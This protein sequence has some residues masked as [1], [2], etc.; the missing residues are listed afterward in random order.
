[1]QYYYVVEMHQRILILKRSPKTAIVRKSYL[2]ITK[3]G[4]EFV[5]KRYSCSVELDSGEIKL[6]EFLIRLLSLGGAL[7]LAL[8][9]KW[10][11]SKILEKARKNHYVTVTVLIRKLPKKEVQEV[12]EEIWGKIPKYIYV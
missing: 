10:R 6:Y 7:P 5:R 3:E 9:R 12:V 1:M 4:I 8:I 2:I 11:E